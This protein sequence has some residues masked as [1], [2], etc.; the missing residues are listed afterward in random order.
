MPQNATVTPGPRRIGPD[1]HDDVTARLLTQRLAA[2]GDAEIEVVFRDDAVAALWEGHPRVRATAYGRR[3]ARLVLTAV[4][5]STP[6]RVAP[7]PIIVGDGPLN[8]TLAEELVAGWS[9]PG[10]PMV[11]HCVGRDE[12]WARDVA[13][14]AGGAARVSWSQGSLRPEPVLRR[15]GELLAGWDAPP[16]RR[17][18]PTGPAVIVAC[19]DDMLT[20]V[21]AAAVA[22][23]VREAR[24]AMIIPGGIRWPQLPGVTQFTLE[25]SAVLALD[26]RFSPMQQLDRLILDDVAWL[27]AADAEATRSEGPIFA[28]VVHSPDGRAAWETQSEELRGQLTKLAGACE[29]LLA[30]GSVELAPSGVREPSAVLLA[31]PELAAM[32]SRILGLLDRDKTPGTWL[33]ALELASRLPVLAARAGFTPR[34]PAGHDP[35]LTP[36]LVELLAPQVHLA[37]Q[38]ISEETG[39]ATGSPL[40]LELWEN[41]DDFTKASNRAAI[42]GSAVTHAAAGLTWRRPTPEGG[43]TLDEALLEE[44]GRLEHRRW[45]IHERRNGRGDHTWAKPWNE[46]KDVQHYDIAIMRHLPRI[47]AAANM[48]LATAP[49]DARV[50][51]S[52]E[53][54]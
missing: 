30:A 40:A 26:P 35:L 16:P 45:A 1:V 5:P 8:A 23:E 24:V 48:E 44:L 13:D 12:N 54:G 25:N 52:P 47:L 29:E 17:G 18:T 42:T 46:I 36:E 19:D 31:P 34:R 53:A 10:Q 14:W 21:V 3:L 33:T 20:P 28:D 11:V 22:R 32:A 51:I 9:E 50:D 39:N 49:P 43:A 41:L 6:D 2:P 37:Y 7:P 27:G 15:I 38:R 4:A